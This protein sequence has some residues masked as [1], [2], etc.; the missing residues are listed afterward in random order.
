[1][2]LKIRLFPKGAYLALFLP[3]FYS[4]WLTSSSKA[5]HFVDPDPPVAICNDTVL[6]SLDATGEAEIGTAS[7]DNGSFDNC[8]PV[9][10]SVRRTDLN[11]DGSTDNFTPTVSFCCDDI[12]TDDMEVTLLVVDAVGNFSFC[13]SVVEVVDEEAPEAICVNGI[14]AIIDPITMMDTMLIS[15]LDD[16]S[17]D[18]CSPVEIS[19]SPDSMV[20]QRIFTCADVYEPTQTIDLYVSDDFGNTSSCTSFLLVSDPNTVCTQG[21]TFGGFI[22]TEE[23]EGIADVQVGINDGALDVVTDATGYYTNTIFYLQDIIIAPVLDEFVK[24]LVEAVAV[25]VLLD[26]E[27]IVNFFSLSPTLSNK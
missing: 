4:I 22:R 13:V 19:F 5:D 10:F 1:M 16:G 21:V 27:S 15:E 3:V 24:L 12:G 7:F 9:T 11:C 2:N 17:Y 18:N 20:T 8:P 23:D 6:V 26:T 25:P 14:Q